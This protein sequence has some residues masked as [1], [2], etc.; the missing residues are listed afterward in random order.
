MSCLSFQ[1]CGVLASWGDGSGVG[2][3][4][5]TSPAPTHSAL[6]GLLTA[7]AGVDRYDPKQQDFVDGYRFA[8]RLD[9]AGT[10]VRDFHTVQTLSRP[11]AKRVAKELR[12]PT[13]ADYLRSGESLETKV[14]YR[15][16]LSGFA[17]LVVVVSTS[18][19]PLALEEL[20]ERLKC[21]RFPIYLGR[22]GCPPA[23]PLHPRVNSDAVE[24]VLRACDTPDL[25]AYRGSD[26]TRATVW[27]DARLPLALEAQQ[28][29]RERAVPVNRRAWQFEEYAVNVSMVE[30]SGE[31]V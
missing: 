1:L 22:R 24:E 11:S 9:A 26:A 8:V 21:P 18:A 19:A 2:D 25:R 13:R 28:T 27:W 12:L 4:R 23:A 20:A 6:V 15:T 16:Y 10:P 14:T 7:A 30:L 5:A 29:V 17:A 3:L 31:E